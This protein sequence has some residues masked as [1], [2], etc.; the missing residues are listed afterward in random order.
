MASASTMRDHVDAYLSGFDHYLRRYRTLCAVERRT[1]VPKVYFTLAAYVLVTISLFFDLGAAFTVSLL[2]WGYPTFR[3]LAAAQRS[4]TASLGA[5]VT[6]FS[7]WALWNTLEAALT[8][9]RLTERIPFYY[10]I[11]TL[12]L[13]WML[14]PKY[15]GAQRMHYALCPAIA[16]VRYLVTG[17]RAP[18][19]PHFATQPPPS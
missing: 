13:F 14:L 1:G 10:V 8:P 11:K 9:A 7:A 19:P 16:R 6:Y 4:D 17:V 2:G 15:A 5:W 3:A 12:F 18:L